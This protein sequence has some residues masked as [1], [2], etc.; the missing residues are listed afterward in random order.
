[1]FAVV[2]RMARKARIE[3]EGA[4]Y[5]VLDRGDR[6]EAIFRDET[7]HER[8]LTTLGEACART[9]WRVHA[10]VLM[11][12]HYH[13]LLETPQPNL[14]AG[15]RWFQTTYTVRFNRRHRLSGHLFQGRYK[16]VL[17]D[18]AE[19]GYFAVLTDYIHLNPVRA[20]IVGL[21][22]RLFDYR[23]SSYPCYAATHR[24]PGWFEPRRVL[25][26]LGLD[27]TAD[28]RRCFA[29]RMRERAVAELIEKPDARRDELRRGWCLGGAS[30]RERMLGLLDTAGEKLRGRREIDSSVRRSHG[31]DEAQRLLVGGLRFFGL[32]ASQ[33]TSLKKSD[34]LKLAIAAAIRT[35]TTVPNAWIAGQLALGHVSRVSRCWKTS[36]ASTEYLSLLTAL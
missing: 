20:R 26:E 1:M 15:M 32:S 29:E 6:R 27:D 9:G 11:R 16:A 22:Q 31:E 14:V 2:S 18:P 5:H 21:D 35:Q 33:L 17:V 24:R 25:G 10:F 28:G 23:W 13:L 3:F 12:N 36:A 4:V 8:F 19:R 30:F 34:P 7:D